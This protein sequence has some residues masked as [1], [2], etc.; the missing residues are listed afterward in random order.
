M[1]KVVNIQKIYTYMYFDIKSFMTGTQFLYVFILLALYANYSFL[2]NC[3]F[4]RLRRI[5]GMEFFFLKS[6]PIH[7]IPNYVV[8]VIVHDI[9]LPFKFT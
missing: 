5:L 7:G 9:P 3:H 4:G 6:I 1:N 8:K 2:L